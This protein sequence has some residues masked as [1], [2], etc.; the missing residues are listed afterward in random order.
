M[1]LTLHPSLPVEVG[2]TA[3]IVAVREDSPVILV[4]P[5]PAGAEPALPSGPFDPLAHRTFEIGLRA[6]VAQQTGA[7]LGYVEQLYT[8]GDRGRHAQAGDASSP[9]CALAL[10]FCGLSKP[11]Q[12]PAT[13][14]A[15]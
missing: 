2:L 1:T 4:A 8:F 7:P 9:P 14:S 5:G 6:W 15:V 12:T 13:R 10:I 11:I 3:A